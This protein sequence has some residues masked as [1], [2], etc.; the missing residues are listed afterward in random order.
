MVIVLDPDRA[1][2]IRILSSPKRYL[3]ADI[4]NAAYQ[5]ADDLIAEH[6]PGKQ[7]SQSLQDLSKPVQG[8]VLA[9]IDYIFRFPGHDIDRMG[10][11]TEILEFDSDWKKIV[12]DILRA[13]KLGVPLKLSSDD[14][15]NYVLTSFRPYVIKIYQDIFSLFFTVA[16]RMI[17][18][19]EYNGKSLEPL[20]YNL[21]KQQIGQMEEVAQKSFD[22]PDIG[23][24]L[25]LY[26]SDDAYDYTRMER[27]KLWFKSLEL[28]LRKNLFTAFGRDD[29]IRGFL[30][31]VPMFI[32]VSAITA[33]VGVSPDLQATNLARKLDDRD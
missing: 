29:Y 32:A 25:R 16:S 30:Y 18:N 3:S 2:W 27:L 12:S 13:E 31:Y 20:E 19:I 6:P 33:L 23:P 10:A 15:E 22:H 9:V 26:A 1:F 11:S 4:R 24:V 7:T 14:D 8:L 21:V 17:R 28:R 5:L